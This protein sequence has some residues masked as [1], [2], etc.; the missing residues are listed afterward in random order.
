M[1]TKEETAKLQKVFQQLDV[2]KDGSGS[3]SIEE[4]RDVLGVGKAISEEVWA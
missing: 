2:N 3:I 4:I 1:V